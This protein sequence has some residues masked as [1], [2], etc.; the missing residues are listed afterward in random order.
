MEGNKAFP[1]ER[2]SDEDGINS[3]RIA[4]LVPFSARLSRESPFKSNLASS[5]LST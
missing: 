1:A 3:K 5:L 4:Q 2:F